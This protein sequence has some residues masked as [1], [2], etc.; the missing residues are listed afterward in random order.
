MPL[1]ALG[2]ACLPIWY[3]SVTSLIVVY[4]FFGLTQV[5]LIFDKVPIWGGGGCF[6]YHIFTDCLLN[7]S[8]DNVS[9]CAILRRK[10]LDQLNKRNPLEALVSTIFN[11]FIESGI[12]LINEHVFLLPWFEAN[13]DAQVGS[14]FSNTPQLNFWQLIW[15]KTWATI[16][17][18]LSTFTREIWG[19]GGFSSLNSFPTMQMC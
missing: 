11:S 5:F 13:L 2:R 17:Q 9:K 6:H 14:I 19:S 16:L 12:V 15:H 18:F 4:T 7:N 3:L 1:A 8:R 10:N